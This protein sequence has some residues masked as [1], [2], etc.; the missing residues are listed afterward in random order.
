MRATANRNPAHVPASTFR[1]QLNRSFQFRD[2]SAVVDYLNDLGITDCYFSPV[3]ASRPGSPHGYDIIDHSRLNPEIGTEAELGELA[4][5]LGLY[6]MGI[7]ADVVPNHMCV[8]STNAWWWDVLENGPSSTYASFFDIDWQPPKEALVGKVLLPVLGD[9]YGRILESGLI[10][11]AYSLGGFVTCFHEKSLP[12]SP[13]SWAM[14]LGPVAMAL[15]NRIGPAHEH[16][17]EMESILTAISHL[18]PGTENDAAKLRERNR[19]KEVIKRRLAALLDAAPEVRATLD[20]ELAMVNGREGDPTS[21]DRLEALLADQPWRLSFWRVAADE[22][23]YRRF[24]DVNELAAI[25]VENP[26]VFAAVHQLIFDLVARGWFRGLRID[27]PDG[28]LDPAGYFDQVQ[29]ACTRD[30]SGDR[31]FYVVAEKIVIGDEQ[32]RSHWA[33]EGTTGYGYLNFL[34]GLFVDG[35]KKAAFKRLYRTFMGGS[36]SY[37]DLVY[38][39]KKLILNVSMSSELNVLS[40]RLE[41]ISE[42]HRFSRD[43]TLE[44]LRDALREVVACFP[45]YRTYAT[46]TSSP[47][48]E[49]ERHVLHAVEEAKRR[50]PAVS[51]SVFDFVRSVLLLQDPNGLIQQQRDERRLFV[52]RLQQFTGPVMAKAVEDTAF[53]RSFPLASLNEV[54]GEPEQFGVSPQLFHTKNYVRRALWPNAMLASSTHDSKRSEDVRARI[55]VLSEIPGDWHQ[56]LRRWHHLNRVH[57]TEVAGLSAPTPN[58]EYLLYQTLLGAWPLEMAEAAACTQFKDRI[59]EYMQKAVRE[60]KTHTSWISPHAPYEDALSRFLYRILDPSRSSEFL[61]SFLSF[62]ERIAKAGMLNSLSQTLLKIA[63]PGVP[64]FYQGCEIWNFTLVDPDNRRPVDYALRRA[65]LDRIREMERKIPPSQV[66]SALMSAPHDGAIKLYLTRRAL[67]H[68][69]ENQ[70]LY[71]K[72]DYRAMRAA[73]PRQKHVVAFARQLGRR[74]LVVAAGRFFLSLLE[75]GNSVPPP[76]AWGDT[77]LLL[78]KE[79]AVASWRELLSGRIIDGAS[80]PHVSELFAILPVAL[81]VNEMNS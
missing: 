52:L 59:R 2:L 57:K 39:S 80:S 46:A 32:L 6:G 38:D 55:N 50:N 8:D 45:V 23:N 72:G 34:N 10:R 19:E 78:R 7:V 9:Q 41:R 14:F 11:I 43:F 37:D 81:L 69:R 76:D 36:L 71:S 64:D 1:V 53:Y 12:L 60:A 27:H 51:E 79:H 29:A 5:K 65:L 42:Q 75:E 48:L 54:G 62:E 20:D 21:F 18:P 70:D 25:R 49:D 63:S 15:R 61:E 22:I 66:A 4:A 31:P 24:F 35:S 56:A 58:D 33:I 77:K 30:R 13:R 67:R 44:S 16:T 40:R 28:L 68:R 17:L 47:D 26:V 73:G 3:L 74:I